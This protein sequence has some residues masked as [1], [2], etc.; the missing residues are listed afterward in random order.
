M[1][2]VI[3][4]PISVFESNCGYA[5]PFSCHSL[6]RSPINLIIYSELIRVS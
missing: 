4:I 1:V 6:P 2:R 3:G 5:Q